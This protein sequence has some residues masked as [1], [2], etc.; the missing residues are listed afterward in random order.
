M[1]LIITLF[2]IVLA[3]S[4]FGQDC[5]S[6]YR[7]AFTERGALEVMDSTYE[8]VIIAVREGHETNCFMGK[9]SVKSGKVVLD[10][11]YVEL[12]DESYENLG[13]KFKNLKPV[14]IKDG[15]SQIIIDK[16]DDLYNVIFLDHLKP[17]KK[18]FKKAPDFDL[19]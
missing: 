10:N 12:E 6:K 3:N 11:F 7:K 9:V 14:E 4:S 13:P 16:R 18:G 8:G 1:R 15:I 5:Y 17:K 19:D 2:I